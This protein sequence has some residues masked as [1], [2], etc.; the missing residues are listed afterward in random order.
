M[1]NDTLFDQPPPVDPAAITVPAEPA[2]EEKGEKGEAPAPLSPL[3]AETPASEAHEA[4]EADDVFTPAPRTNPVVAALRQSGLYLDALGEGRHRITCP[5][6]SEHGGDVSSEAEYVEPTTDRPIG[7]FSCEHGHAD[8]RDAAS[9]IEYLGLVTAVARCKP[10]IR[11]SPGEL[12][13]AVDAAERV[14]ATDGSFFQAG[15]A[16]VRVARDVSTGELSTALVTDQP[17]IHQLAAAIDWEKR[18]RSSAGWVTCD[19]PSNIVQMLL[20]MHGHRHLPY[21]SGLARQPF[22]RPDG[23]LV[24]AAGYDAASRTFAAFDPAAFPMPEPTREE[25]KKALGLLMTLLREFP[26]ASG[27][28][29]AAALCAML[30]ATVRGSLD[31]APAFNISASSYGSGKSYLASLVSLFAGPG[32]AQAV[33]YPATG[34]EATKVVLSLLV[35]RPPAILFDDMQ[36]DWVPHGAINKMLTQPA[37]TE[38]VLGASRTA[39]VGTNTLVLGTGNNVVP[40]RDM[41]RRV[42]SIYLAP[43]TGTPATID[44]R[45]N[46]VADLRADRG[47]YVAAALTIVRAHAAAGSPK[48]DVPRI[49]TFDAW[50]ERCRHPLLWLGTP[51]PAAS[52]ID[53]IERDPD[54]VLLEVLLDE[55]YQLFMSRPVTVRKL[56][57]T[58]LDNSSLEDAL[59]DLP[60]VEGRHINPNKLG[61]YL[62]KNLNRVAGGARIEEAPEAKER[63]AWKVVLVGAPSSGAG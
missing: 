50:A 60:V 55:W 57:E 7:R 6:A 31:L 36:T 16:I 41:R 27:A 8:K 44:H 24:T 30:T 46:P 20:K 23:T 10:R 54:L 48:A 40:L 52:L 38:R 13:R 9:L 43:N 19:P 61:W 63:K 49:A 42:L 14:L 58:A 25:A 11:V 47:R 34:E 26:F 18:D 39:T 15:D 35:Q 56:I 28:D 33:S 22:F 53:Q 29:L 17:L 37:I 5:W 51:D 62:R 2:A 3:P 59:M 32:G 45:G 4:H 1:L 12:N 21:L